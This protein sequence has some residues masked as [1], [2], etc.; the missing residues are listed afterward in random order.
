MKYFFKGF[1]TSKITLLNHCHLEILEKL[2]VLAIFE[3]WNFYPENRGKVAVIRGKV[4]SCGKNHGHEFL[5]WQGYS[6]TR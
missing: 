4:K 6:I 5:E 2:H 1:E 3:K